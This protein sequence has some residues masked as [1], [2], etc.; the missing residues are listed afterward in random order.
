MAIR[1]HKSKILG[2]DG[3]PIELAVLSREIA[4]A[5]ITGV[6]TV[7]HH[8]S[9][10]SNLSPDRLALIL[11][12]AE[13]GEHK[14]YLT[15]AEEMEERDPH[16]ASVLGT[17][18]RAVSGL[19]CTVEAASDDAVDQKLADAVRE[20]IRKPNF[21]D[22][23]DDCLDAIGKGYS[24]VEMMWDRSAS[25][26]MPVEYIWRDPRF[27]MLDRVQGRELR[28]ID[29]ADLF[30]GVPLPTYK[31]IVH[32]PRLK[33]GLIIRG[34]VA[35]LAAVSYMCKAFT[36]TDWMAFAEVFGMPLRVG[37]Y[38]AN[39]TEKDIQTLI[40]A[41]TNIGTD[42][43]AVIP[44][45]MKIE[46]ED[47]GT[48]SGGDS[49]Y[50]KLAS[51]LD[52]QVSKGVLGQTMTADDGSSQSQAQVHNDVR[53]DILRAD[54]RQ[55]SN[56]LNQYLVKAFIDLNFGPQEEYPRIQLIV[57]DAEDIN[58]L[59]NALEKLVPLGL[60]VEQSVVRDKFGLPDPDEGADL[61]TKA[62]GPLPVG[63]AAN[64]QKSCAHC[65]VAHNQQHAV[66]DAFDQL[67]GDSSSDW[68]P[69]LAPIIDPVLALA[70]RCGSYEEFLEKLPTLLDE[71]DSDELVKR[72]AA[73]TFKARALGNADQ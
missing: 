1:T 4:T 54:A 20:L 25:P 14:D 5:S 29:E 13:E 11:R 15:L 39:A 57:R 16:Y 73:A 36:L 38:G 63:A 60:K 8:G 64:R 12:N 51:W 33:S 49:L 34:G 2:A 70:Q 19:E 24:A 26:W 30:N 37:K 67:E 32:R 47:K 72:L 71:I 40:S 46:F 66:S 61:L 27:F 41:V 45:S 43:G 22:M 6:R 52:K 48:N 44:D 59:T 7:W 28:L 35:R 17:R 18:K 68:Q 9:V 65:G 50:E 10:A 53:I 62:A 23:L 42:A 56:T 21:G 31:F 58:A 55:L 69:Q 3:T